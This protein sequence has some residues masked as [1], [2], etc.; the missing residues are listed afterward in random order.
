MVAIVTGRLMLWKLID[1]KESKLQNNLSVVIDLLCC[2]DERIVE[3][4]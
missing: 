3:Y 2:F 4:L 1:R